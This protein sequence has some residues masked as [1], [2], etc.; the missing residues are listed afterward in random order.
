MKAIWINNILYEH[1]DK[2]LNY[3]NL[4]PADKYV[5]RIIEN[6]VFM[7]KGKQYTCCFYPIDDPQENNFH[8]LIDGKWYSSIL[9]NK[10]NE[11]VK[12]YNNELNKKRYEQ[13]S[14]F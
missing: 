10:Y 7:E 5:K 1:Q 13:V 11:L 2:V 14:L 9:T 12:F 8:Y 6:A 4:E 3:Y